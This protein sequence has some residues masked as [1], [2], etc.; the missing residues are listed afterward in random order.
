MNK[1]S[2]EM[3]NENQEVCP[4]CGLLGEYDFANWS[5]EKKGM[6]EFVHYICSNKHKFVVKRL[7]NK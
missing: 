1:M 7:L 5:P 2:K 4:E 3:K 6:Y